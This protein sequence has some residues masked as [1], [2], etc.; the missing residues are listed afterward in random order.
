[1]IYGRWFIA[2]WLVWCAWQTH[3][4]VPVWQSELSLWTHAAEKTPLLPHALINL[5]KATIA[6]GN[7]EEGIEIAMRGYNLEKR[8]QDAVT[9]CGDRILTC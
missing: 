9:A 3:Q 4:Y 6:S 5:G 7:E 8:R 2:V 1:M